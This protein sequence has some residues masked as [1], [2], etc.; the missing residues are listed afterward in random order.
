MTLKNV[1]SPKNCLNNSLTL[2]IVDIIM[3]NDDVSMTTGLSVL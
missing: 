3:S 1:P 2:V